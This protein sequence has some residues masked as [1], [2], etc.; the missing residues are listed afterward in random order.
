LA[1]GI[2][3]HRHKIKTALFIAA[4]VSIIFLPVKAYSKPD[5][6]AEDVE[7]YLPYEYGQ[8]FLCGQGNNQAPSHK[9]DRNRYAW[10][11]AMPEGT[12]LVAVASGEVVA[13]KEDAAGPTGS[14]RDNNYVLIRHASGNSSF[15]CHIKHN[16]AL[17]EVGQKVMAGDLVA[18]SGNTGSSGSPHLHFAIC[19]GC[20]R[21]K[22]IP[23]KFADVPGDGIPKTGDRPVSKNFPIRHMKEYKEISKALDRYKLCSD[24]GCLEA[25]PSM[26]KIAG[27]KMQK[28]LDALK[29]IIEKRDSILAA[30]EK[31]AKSSLEAIRKAMENKDMQTAVRLAYFGQRDFARSRLAKEFKT[32]HSELKK[33]KGY[34]KALPELQDEIKYRKKIKSAIRNELKVD[35]KLRKE[36]EKPKKKMLSVG[37]RKKTPY[38][39]VIKQYEEALAIAP[40]KSAKAALTKHI[41]ELRAREPKELS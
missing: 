9:N 38:G 23:A 6:K 27:I 3:M 10:D 36:T 32:I 34:K 14:W 26:K 21:G 37:G 28:E 8:K 33:E 40:G 16:G 11:F 39:R 17:V 1:K 35:K 18:L 41:E 19:K 24:L 15:Y 7:Y 29:E 22:P 12:H 30:Y 31:A 2:F 4:A 13:I 25:L 5:A 20:S